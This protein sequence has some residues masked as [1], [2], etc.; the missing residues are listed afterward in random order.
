MDGL[1]NAPKVSELGISGGS[2]GRQSPQDGLLMA[3]SEGQSRSPEFQKLL[4]DM[5]KTLEE[6][7]RIARSEFRSTPDVVGTGGAK[8]K[9]ELMKDELPEEK[10]FWWDRVLK[11]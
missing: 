4:D 9:Y 10:K 2:K 11:D 8:Q 7:A 5:N 3:S 6:N 1:L